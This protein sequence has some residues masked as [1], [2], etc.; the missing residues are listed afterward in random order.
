MSIGDLQPRRDVGTTTNGE[1]PRVSEYR[2]YLPPVGLREHVLCFWT[3]SIRQS[4]KVYAHRVLPDACLDLVL[5][6]GQP[7]AVIGP[8]TE[9]FIAQ[10]APGTRITGVRFHPG[11]AAAIL[12]LPASELINQEAALGDIWKVA[13]REPFAR[14][15]EFASFRAR[16]FELEAALLR[17]LRNAAQSDATVGGAIRWLAR[18]PNA[19]IEELSALAG[20]SSRQ[21]QRRFSAAVGYGPK[22]FQSVLRFQRLLYLASN[23]IDR[24]SLA[25]VAARVG[26]AD[27]SHMNREVRR[28]SGKSPS[29][30]L[31]SAGSTLK[32]T[33]LV[34]SNEE[35]VDFAAWQ[36]VAPLH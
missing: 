5:F 35:T 19:R 18:N 7:P 15:G 8:W 9:S 13:M 17:H 14:I 25:N 10:L 22:M 30:L 24:L 16:R 27:Q 12:G 26:Y 36:F 4:D 20:I 3:Q 6:Q 29:E 34:A 11:K 28:F 33:D 21:M 2:E 32:L 23:G 1:S 31:S